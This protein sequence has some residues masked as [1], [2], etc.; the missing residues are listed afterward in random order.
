[1]ENGL[2]MVRRGQAESNLEAFEKEIHIIIEVRVSSASTSIIRGDIRVDRITVRSN[3]EESFLKFRG[4]LKPAL[5]T[6][7]RS[8]LPKPS[9]RLRNNGTP[10]VSHRSQARRSLLPSC[11]KPEEVLEMLDVIPIGNDV[12]HPFRHVG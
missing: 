10:L 12:H 4:T 6:G 8:T 11:E 5:Q 1:M 9:S 2:V 7:P 3:L